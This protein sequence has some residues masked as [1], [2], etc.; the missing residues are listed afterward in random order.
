MLILK[1]RKRWRVCG[2]RFDAGTAVSPL[3]PATKRRKMLT[4][5]LSTQRHGDTQEVGQMRIKSGG[6]WQTL[7]T[8]WPRLPFHDPPPTPSVW[9]SQ[10][11]FQRWSFNVLL[12]LLTRLVSAGPLL[13]VVHFYRPNVKLCGAGFEYHD[14]SLIDGLAIKRWGSFYGSKVTV[15]HDWWRL[16]SSALYFVLMKFMVRNK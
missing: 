16:F 8:T 6:G 11:H 10:F 7:P 4:P 5:M 2:H 3:V 12:F 9:I 1:A 15:V 13:A 14:H